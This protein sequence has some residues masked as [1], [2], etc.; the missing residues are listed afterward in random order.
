MKT[1]YKQPNP[2]RP[3]DYT[4]FLDGRF[5][6]FEAFFVGDA[7]KNYTFLKIF[8]TDKILKIK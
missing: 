1:Q 3:D 6:V 2:K 7:K 4:T 8:S 5:R